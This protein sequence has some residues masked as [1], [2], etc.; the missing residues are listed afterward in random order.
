MSTVDAGVKSPNTAK[1]VAGTH[2]FDRYQIQMWCLLGGLLLAIAWCY[3]NTLTHVARHW[4][5]PK[6]SHGYLVP[7]F[8]A[9]LVWMR[10]EPWGNV[11]NPA[12]WAGVGM[13]A[14]GLLCR[15]ILTRLSS[16]VPEMYTL[17]PCVMGAFL[18]VGGWA[19]LRWAGPAVLFLFFMFP[20]P[21]VIDYSL[22]SYLQSVATKASTYL[23]QTMGIA[24]YSEGNCRWVWSKL[25]AVCAC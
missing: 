11:T 25:A 10:R 14:F 6:Y 2:E 22:L 24:C 20:L 7:L 18:V 23:L 15:L 21:S 13:I 8:T 16:V 12:R 3:W 9:V 19:T 4:D 5:D 1:A 17:L